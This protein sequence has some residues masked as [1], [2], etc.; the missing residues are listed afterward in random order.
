[1]KIN[2]TQLIE[3]VKNDT[4]YSYRDCQIIIN[5]FIKVFIHSLKSGCVIRLTNLGIFKVI[6]RPPKDK[7]TNKKSYYIYEVDYQISRSLHNR[8]NSK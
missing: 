8:L 7:S 2:K 1:M 3:A 5:S 4:G 6:K